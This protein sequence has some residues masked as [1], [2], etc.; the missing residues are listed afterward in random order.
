LEPDECYLVG[1]QDKSAPDLAIEVIG[2]SG[3]IDKLEIYRRLDVGE[4]S[5]SPTPTI[6]IT[7][8]GAVGSTATSGTGTKKLDLLTHPLNRVRT[9]RP[10]NLEQH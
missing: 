4:V 7:S 3:G 2:T 1:D 5:P 9:I 8:S 10:V 6:S